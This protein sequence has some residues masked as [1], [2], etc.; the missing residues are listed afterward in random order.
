[1]NVLFLAPGYPA[2]MPWFVRGLR[3]RG[4]RV[5]GVGDGPENELPAIARENLAGYLRAP[6]IF[7]DGSDLGPVV[8]GLGETTIDR[9][10]CNWEPGVL[11]AGRLRDALKVHG[12]GYQALLPYRDKDIMKQ[13]VAAAGLRCPKHVMATTVAQAREATRDLGYPVI[14]KPLA[15]AGSMDTFRCDSA[16]EVEVAL[17]RMGHVDAVNVEEFIDGEEFTFDTI[18]HE[19]RPLFHNICWYRPRPLIARSVE[20][21]S[22]Q[23]VAL[24]DPDAPHL[25][26]GRD[27]GFAVLKALDFRTGFTHMEWYMKSDGEVVFGEIAARPPGA[28][29]VDLMNWA[30]DID[31]Y[32]GFAEAELTGTFSIDLV[33]KYNAAIVFKR[34]QGKGIIRRVEGVERLRER[35]GDRLVAMELLPVGAHRR[36]WVQTLVSDGWVCVRDPDLQGLMD[37]ADFVGTDLQ[38]YAS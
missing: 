28:H 16:A 31:L 36:D 27:L 20:W 32:M 15:G 12:M 17:K 9:V 4:A 11:L 14:L 24:R 6:G 29:T 3:T 7:A 21:I 2:E 1:M 34:A 5:I 8:R 38:M 22:P 30:S 23:T 19:G 37:A 13:K 18:C 26:G 10:V 25:R 35:L 33:R